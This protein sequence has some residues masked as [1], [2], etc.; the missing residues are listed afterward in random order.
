M[1]N[2]INVKICGMTRKADV[3]QALSLGADH[4]GFIVYPKSPRAL[5]LKVA[6]KL[7]AL[8]PE[9]KRVVVDVETSLDDLKRYKEAGFDR[10]QIH[11]NLPANE[12]RI[13]GYSRLVGPDQLWLAPRLAPGEPFPDWLLEYAK[14]VLLDTYSSKQVG[15]TGHTGDF[16]QFAALKRR[17][18]DTEWILAGG[19]NPSNILAAIQASTAVNVDVNSGVESSPGVKDPE[20]LRLL[21]QALKPGE[22]ER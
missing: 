19:L 13:K 20:K 12:Q 18:T 1:D 4:V 16:K 3:E 2:P 9:G 17:F 10:F 21:F 11:V 15:G 8:A 6:A 5:P 14:T 22:S 7:A